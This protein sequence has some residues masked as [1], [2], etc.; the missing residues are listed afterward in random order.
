MAKAHTRTTC[1][2]MKQTDATASSA[3]VGRAFGRQRIAV[4]R[5]ASFWERA[6]SCLLPKLPLK[7]LPVCAVSLLLLLRAVSLPSANGQSTLAL[8]SAGPRAITVAD[9]IRMT[10]LG[11]P[12]YWSGASSRG[13]TAQ[14]SQ[15]GTKFVVI[16]RRG[17]LAL[18]TNEYSMLLWHTS[19]LL[20]S[21]APDV[22]LMMSSSSNRPAIQDVRWLADNETL[23]FLGENPGAS[24]QLYT[25]N[26]RTRSLRK[27]TNHVSNLLAYSANASGNRFAFL[28]E[29]PLRS[30]FDEKAQREGVL[31]GTQHLMKL[32]TGQRGEDFG[33]DKLI[34]IQS[35]GDSARSLSCSA[36]IAASEVALSP[37]AMYAI[38]PAYVETVPD[39]WRQYSGPFMGEFATKHVEPGQYSALQTYQLVDTRSGRCR[40][41]LNAPLPVI[42]GS[43]IAW[44]PDSRSVVITNTYLPLDSTYGPERRTRQSTTFVAE[45]GIP[46]GEVRVVSRQE[47]RSIL[48]YVRWDQRTSD[49]VL[50]TRDRD[51]DRPGAK[52][53]FRKNSHGWELVEHGGTGESSP[54]ILLD[55]DMNSPP[56][57]YAI[58]PPAQQKALLLDLNPQFRDLKFGKVKEIQWRGSQG[59]PAK[60]GLF[61]PVPYTPGRRY[62]LVIQ[63]HGWESTKFMVDGAW[64]TAYA[65]RPL[66]ATG[67]MVLQVGEFAGDGNYDWWY[68]NANT[69]KEVDRA[70]SSYEGAIDV[71]DRE[72]L[73]DRQRV[74]IIGFSRTC[75]FVKYALTHSRFQFA[76]ASVTAGIDAGYLQYMMTTTSA[77]SYAFE[78]EG[79]NGGA[80]FG[81]GLKM[82]MQR[83]PG[84]NIDRVR[85]PVRITAETPSGALFEWEWFAAL[86]RLGKPVEMVMMQDGDHLLQKP[87][88]RMISQQGNVDWFR[89]WLKGE[90]D[91]DPAKAEQYARW[92]VLRKL[93]QQQVAGD[94]AASEHK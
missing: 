90:E 76:A 5:A 13:L 85:T 74:G 49:L 30:L 79:I 53:F 61:Y 89:F 75:L 84:F 39:A 2:P 18:N 72:G 46:S 73:I 45:V 19:Q 34:F 44:A 64:T 37:D 21:P 59:F 26:V 66:A 10:K 8:K 24:Q 58:S 29:A 93:Q 22:L 68:A 28:A 83:S 15:D 25:L 56:K 50:E 80:P 16:L 17:N 11:H 78:I 92:R 6:D 81:R 12:A 35:E 91:P 38:V 32:V 33:Q 40:P 71:L 27:V 43:E 48:R 31:V 23:S 4:H 62:P 94:T 87:W 47:G 3:R 57:I 69:A 86:T 51:T 36:L 88:E 70:V 82:W 7:A 63:T 1:L 52:A 60:G 9:A 42:N 55:E 77:R 20:R 54:E 67:I 65:A 14:F 41:L